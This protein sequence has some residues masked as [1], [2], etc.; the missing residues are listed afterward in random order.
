MFFT[1]TKTA[2]ALG[3]INLGRVFLYR[4]GV[5]FNFNPIKKITAKIDQ[6]LFFNS[7]ISEQLVNNSK[8]P[9]NDQWLNKQCY[10]GWKVN[11]SSEVPNWHKSILTGKAVQSPHRSWW[12]IPDFDSELGDIKGVWEASRF[13]WVLCFAQQAIAGDEQAITKLNSWLQN[14]LDNNLPYQ[15]VNWKCGQEASIRVMHLAMASLI[16]DQQKNSQKTLLSFIKAHLK[17]I[18]PTISYAIAQDNNHG[19]S[20]AAALYIGGSWLVKNGVVEGE[21]WQNIGLKWL[22]NR[23]NKLIKED[24]GFSQYSTTYHRVMLDTYSM[25]EVWRLKLNLPKFSNDLYQK[26]QLATNWL[27]QFTQKETGDAPNLGANDGARL[28]PLTNTDYRDFRPSVQLAS[29]LFCR[30]KAWRNN[31]SWNLPLMWLSIDIPADSLENQ[32]DFHFDKTGYFGLR[33]NHNNAFAM[34]TYPKFHFRPSQSDALHVDFWCAGENLLRDGGTF[35]YNAGEKYINY[36]GGTKS[37]NTIEF[38]NRDQMPRLSRFLLGNWLKSKSIVWDKDKKNCSAVYSDDKGATHSRA[39]SL[40]DDRLKVIDNVSGFKQCG[41]LRWRLASGNWTLNGNE[42]SNGK[43]IILILAD[44]NISRLELTHGKESR[45]YY[46]ETD[47]PVLEIE[48]QQ[49][50]T[51]ITEYKY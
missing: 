19:T 51:I 29:V 41:I 48:F 4:I 38:D 46:Q 15:G 12:L 3:I 16:L 27:Y 5:K 39:L 43:H 14:W 21:V 7:I 9:T 22:E 28:L 47:I 18:A 10:F 37:H 30:K 33:A 23:A 1:K 42:L 49:A 32:V 17:R 6:G 40:S 11:D 31:G 2:L 36:Y 20:E 25:V 24:G 44:I 34:M 8:F 13:D 45:Y 35:S 50:G 26:L